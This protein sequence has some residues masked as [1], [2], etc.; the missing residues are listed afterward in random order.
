LPERGR[1]GGQVELRAA[2]Q[3][4]EIEL[5]AELQGQAG[6]AEALQPAEPEPV[7]AVR[8]RLSQDAAD[9]LA[10]IRVSEGVVAQR[11]RQIVV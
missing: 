1:E 4:I 7:N 3:D 9:R 2:A 5:G 6:K 8:G 11:S 10:R